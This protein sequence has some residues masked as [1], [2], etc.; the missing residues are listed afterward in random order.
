MC[1]RLG[2]RAHTTNTSYASHLTPPTSHHVS[3]APAAFQGTAHIFRFTRNNTHTHR[4]LPT[5]L[6]TTT[7]TLP[8]QQV[9]EK[10][11]HQTNTQNRLTQLQNASTLLQ[12]KACVYWTQTSVWTRRT[13][14]STHFR[15]PTPTPHA[16]SLR[17]PTVVLIS[18]LSMQWSFLQH[19]SLQPSAKENYHTDATTDERK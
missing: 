7:P 13:H 14:A 5:S 4:R 1:R 6:P 9:Y 3:Y 10:R 16:T 2:I 19:Y 17:L 15:F 11:T 18:P 8:Q 12:G